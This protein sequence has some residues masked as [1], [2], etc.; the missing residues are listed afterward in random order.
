VNDVN[1]VPGVPEPHGLDRAMAWDMR[2]EGEIERNG[3]RN[4]ENVEC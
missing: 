2:D 4:L 3:Y 1:D